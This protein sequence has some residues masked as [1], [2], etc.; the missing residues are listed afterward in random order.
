MSE[1]APS[2]QYADPG[3]ARDASTLGMWAFLATEVLFFG[4]LIGAY[5]DYRLYYSQALI[6]AASHSK[7]VF[8]TINTAA[9][10][11]SSA[12]MAMAVQSVEAGARKA[13]TL[14]LGAT[15]GLGLL[16]I[17]VKFTEYWLEWKEHLLPGPGFDTAKAGP[18]GQLFFTWYF[19]ATGAHAIHLLIGI[20]FVSFAAVSI[21]RNRLPQGLSIR[22]LG[23]YWHFID[24]VWIF[25]FPLIYLAGRNG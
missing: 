10:L 25:L 12:C 22:I 14:W 16:F 2:F 13:A 8:G 9:L 6:A 4:V 1:R 21:A 20:A 23:L 17:A 11:T 19:C 18:V 5:L 24:I 15:A 3:Q 7:I